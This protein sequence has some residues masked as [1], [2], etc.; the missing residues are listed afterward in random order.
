MASP[1]M[2]SQYNINSIANEI[3]QYTYIYIY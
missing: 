3:Y 1:K 2:K